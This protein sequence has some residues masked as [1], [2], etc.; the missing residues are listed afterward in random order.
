MTLAFIIW[1]VC[2]GIFVYVLRK[3]AKEEEPH[4]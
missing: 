3:E 2:T 4:E 1:G